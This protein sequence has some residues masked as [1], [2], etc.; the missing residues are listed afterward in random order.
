MNILRIIE[1]KKVIAI[2]TVAFIAFI[3]WFGGT[4]I[5]GKSQQQ[6]QYQTTQ[7]EKT[8]LI[9]SLSVSGNV[10]SGGQVAV[11]SNTTGIIEKVYVKNGDTVKA[12][13]NL[14]TVKSTASPEEIASSYANYQ[15]SVS[16]L[17]ATQQNKL[18]L[19]AQKL[20]K[21]QAVKQAQHDVD[22]KNEN[23][24][25]PQTKQEYTDFEKESIDATLAQVKKDYDASKEKYNLADA[26]I[27][28]A[29]TDVNSSWLSYLA[30][31]NATIT[32]PVGGTIAN[33][34]ASI[35]DY[36]TASVASSGG[37]S[38]SSSSS[39]GIGGNAGSNAAASSNSSDSS[40]PVLYV[41]NFSSVTVKASVN[42]IDLPKIKLGQKATVTLDA[43]SD[44]T[45]V[46]KV[47]RI[48]KIG[49]VSSGVVTYNVYVTIDSPPADIAA[50]MTASANIQI[51]RRD[52]AIAIP[53][54][55]IKTSGDQSI[56]TV[57]KKDG[58]TEERT[59]E[60]GLASD[61]Q[62]EIISGLKEGEQVVTGSSD[63]SGQQPQSGSSPFGGGFGGMGGRRD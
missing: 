46:G 51:D 16:A 15:K 1:K 12:G 35:G 11:S 19:E 45:F 49:S 27:A 37:A 5:F 17:K 25:N 24:I 4:R 58:K 20:Q 60:T 52:N 43:F 14:F 55:A 62:T 22:Y 39:G 7:A 57:L 6:T 2:I 48:D 31:K 56:V 53:S 61:S 8:S 28:A 29:K 30:I 38:S 54:S 13:A 21:K 36:V 42:E 23:T 40:T 44:K 41:T 59:V 3:A 63:A 10:Y 9:S 50:G 33:L 18:V 26:D 47:S 34:S 32:A